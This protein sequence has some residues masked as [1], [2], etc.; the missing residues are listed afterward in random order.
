MVKKYFNYSEDIKRRE[1]DLAHVHVSQTP[2]FGGY[3]VLQT[4][5]FM[6]Q[7]KLKYSPCSTITIIVCL[8]IIYSVD[9][10]YTERPI[11][12]QQSSTGSNLNTYI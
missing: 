11:A 12:G 2:M 1:K 8:D 7:F 6:E 3:D 5:S 9:G 4:F 10:I